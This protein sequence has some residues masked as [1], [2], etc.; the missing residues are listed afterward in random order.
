MT[1]KKEIEYRL[2]IQW[3]ATPDI[4]RELKTQTAFAEK[5]N[6]AE[7]TLSEWKDRDGFWEAVN[8]ENKKL[9]KNKTAEVLNAL[10]RK[11]TTNAAAAEVKLWLEFVEDWSA[12]TEV[13]IRRLESA[14]RDQISDDRQ[15]MLVK[16]YEEGMRKILI[17]VKPAPPPAS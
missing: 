9:C 4:A 8:K 2:F 1:I 11:I 10:Y 17:G 12:K 13:K 5:F 7:K 15:K 6:V 3:L 16:E 14:D